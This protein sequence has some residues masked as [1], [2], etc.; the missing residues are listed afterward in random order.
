MALNTKTISAGVG[1]I[2][3]ID[4]GV[5]ASSARQVLD[6]DGTGLPLYLT[7]TRLGVGESSPDCT[8]HIKGSG[9]DSLAILESTDNNAE[10]EILS[11]TAGSAETHNSSLIFGSGG[12]S[13]G[14]IYYDHH[15]T[16]ASQKFIIKVGDDATSAMTILGNGRV[17]IGTTSPVGML[18]LEDDT[19]NTPSLYITNISPSADDLGGNL[20]FRLSD[21]GTNLTTG[22]VLGDISFTGRDNSDDTYIE[23]A[24]IRAKTNGTPG[25]DDMPTQLQFFTN[26]G[27]DSSTQRMCILA[28]GKVGINED[29]PDD[30]LHIK[31]STSGQ[32]VMKVEHTHAS[33]ANGINISYAGDSY[34]DS[35]DY[36]IYFQTGGG[37]QF[38]CSGI[39]ELWQETGG[40]TINSDRNLKD[41]IVDGTSKLED[42]NKLKVRN[43]N[44]KKYPD[45]KHLG[46]IAQEVQ[47]I[48]PSLVKEYITRE[49]DVENSIEEK[50]SLGIQQDAFV[51]MLVKA[52][53][54]LSAKV[55]ALESA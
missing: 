41:N 51:P 8:L 18:E 16:P 11:S 47:E 22:D 37:A 40:S 31:E 48:F 33:E 36:A 6:G 50:K 14:T 53:Q 25:T 12:A 45:K 35:D 43:F 30:M 38:W 42:I 54:E 39:G 21:P 17:G 2:L 20:I 19:S 5:D 7:T 3:N 55:T 46:F 1:D 28:N 4:G 29:A 15:A 26:S 9:T 23:G 32:Y 52:I 13:K 27:S 24:R 49:A 10:L 34:S 44:F